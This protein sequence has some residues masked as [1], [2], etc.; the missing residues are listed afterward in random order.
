MPDYSKTTATF[1]I[2]DVAPQQKSADDSHESLRRFQAIAL[3]LLAEAITTQSRV[4]FKRR[5]IQP[6]P[7]TLWEDVDATALSSLAH[8]ILEGCVEDLRIERKVSRRWNIVD[9]AKL[10]NA[11]RFVVKRIDDGKWLSVDGV[12]PRGLIVHITG[13]PPAI[14]TFDTLADRWEWSD[15]DSDPKPCRVET[16][17]WSEPLTKQFGGS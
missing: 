6:P 2:S 3:S 16:V 15:T 17:E 12:N 1:R 5:F 7:G 10:M 9:V 13:E 14:V 11:G 8:G 4:Q